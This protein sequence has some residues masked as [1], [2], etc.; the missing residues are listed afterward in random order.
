MNADGSQTRLT[1]TEHV[2]TDANVVRRSA[3]WHHHGERLEL[4]L[5]GEPSPASGERWHILCER[6]ADVV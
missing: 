6:Y 5:R 3:G 4:H 2:L 1:L